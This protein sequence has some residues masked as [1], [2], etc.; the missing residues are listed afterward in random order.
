LGKKTNRGL[1]RHQG[2][3]EQPDFDVLSVVGVDQRRSVVKREAVER[4]VYPM[5]A[6]AAR[7]LDEDVVRSPGDLDLAMVMGTGFP[8]FRGGLLRFADAEGLSTI[9]DGLRKW[10]D[11]LGER[12]EPP[13]PLVE[14]AKSGRGFYNG[15]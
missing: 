12:F 11:K 5:V 14:R 2:K 15:A 3:K 13:A 7:C 8:P 1:Y 9:V 10:Q 6:E 4:C